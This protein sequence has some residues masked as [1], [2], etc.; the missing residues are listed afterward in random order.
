M[1]ADHP[2]SPKPLTVHQ[3]AELLGI[4]PR[5]LYRLIESHA[6]PY[7]RMGRNRSLI[8][9]ARAD[10]LEYLERSRV[11]GPDQPAPKP[12]PK[13]PARLPVDG[14]VHLRGFLPASMR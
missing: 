5:S 3:A 2:N 10:V 4:S 6:L 11:T 12:M 9:L 7:Y 14:V 13:R 1:P 8:R